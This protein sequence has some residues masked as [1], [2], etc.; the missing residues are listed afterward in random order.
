[1][2]LAAILS[3]YMARHFL[4]NFLGLFALF[5]FLI[6]MFDCVELLRRASSKPNVGFSDVFEMAALKLPHMGQKAFPF[7]AMFGG[8][9]A[10]WRLNRHHELVVTRGAGVSVWQFLL[11]V[12]LA[13]FLLGAFQVGFLNPMASQTLSRYERLESLHFKGHQSLLAISQT[14]LWLRQANGP[15]QSVIHA[16][17]VTQDG[18]GVGLRDVTVFVY[19]GA[20]EFVER[21]DADSARL[22]N[23]FWRMRGVTVRRPEEPAVQKASLRL[24]T[25][26]TA[27][28][29]QDSF[30]APETMSF[31]EL[32]AFIRTLENSGFSATRHRLHW[33]ALMASPFLMCAMVMI[34]GTFT[35]RASQR[36][37]AAWITA[38]GALTGF[39]LY[40]FSD[41]VFAMGLSDNIPAT[42]AAWTPAGVT[43]ML[44]LAA[45]LH[46][47]DG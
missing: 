3:V 28:K 37:G 40:F 22:E 11:P 23:G 4:A 42:L 44:G 43:T 8:M 12:L 32:P 41:V 7:A 17:N 47:E 29:I 18:P 20:D 10:F 46:M 31:W 6:F 2:R 16:A 26:L 27:A 30:A 25:G 9:A 38:G 13:A 19:K 14:G 5:I 39:V 45:L 34:A 21:I 1:M 33:H 36:S 35:L 24:E 15:D